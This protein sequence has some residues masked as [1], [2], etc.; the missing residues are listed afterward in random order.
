MF[1]TRRASIVV[2]LLSG[3]LIPLT[4]G[5]T[6]TKNRLNDFTDVFGLGLGVGIGANMR[7]TQYVQAGVGLY[8]VA[9]RFQ[10]RAWRN[11]DYGTEFGLSPFFHYRA[12]TEGRLTVLAKTL[13]DTK[14]QDNWNRWSDGNLWFFYPSPAEFEKNYD[15]RFLDFGVSAYL[16]IGMDLDF[17]I[18]EL[19]DF[20]VG[21]VTLDPYRDDA[22]SA[23][24]ETGK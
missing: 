20:L 16:L 5:C 14:N 11:V 7:V 23:P 9:T 15:R 8:D 6:Y 13:L 4:T 10:N 18:L 24:S 1:A 19:G 17:S 3:V 21:L 22:G 12:S 2:V